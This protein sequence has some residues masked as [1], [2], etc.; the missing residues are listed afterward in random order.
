MDF[1]NS[2]A[3]EQM[4]REYN[5][6]YNTAQA[7]NKKDD[8]IYLKVKINFEKICRLF[9]MLKNC[10]YN[11]AR[12]NYKLGDVFNEFDSW[13]KEAQILF[14][15]NLDVKET[16]EKINHKECAII[17]IELLNEYIYYLDNSNGNDKC[18]Q[19]SEKLIFFEKTKQLYID[20]F[21]IIKKFYMNI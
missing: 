17:F 1:L 15:N 4:A 13:I 5:L 6:K 7:L 9:Y 2:Y 10:F 12:R 3:F 16:K 8:E 21:K 18:I 14:E 11:I 19:N 20:F